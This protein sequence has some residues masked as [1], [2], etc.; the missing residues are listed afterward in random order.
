MEIEQL[1]PNDPRLTETLALIQR[2]F[3]EHD[4][5]IDPPSSMHRLTPE[6]IGHAARNGHLWVIG[7]PPVACVLLSRKPGVLHLSKLAVH[8]AHRGEGH[9]R[10]LIDHA[11]DL[12]QALG[13][14]AV[15]LQTRVEL[16]DNHTAF[17]AMG[18]R[19]VA[20]TAHPGYD[21]ATSIT[22][23]KGV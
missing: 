14:R 10:R 19:K 7:A 21:R 11:V 20:E 1:S 13:L 23:Q 8:P 3:A 6:D 4:G 22:M 12:A 16:T 9:A 17:E 2:A 5:R 15:E 18:F